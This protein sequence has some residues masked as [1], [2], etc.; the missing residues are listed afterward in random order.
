MRTLI[1]RFDETAN[2]YH[3]DDLISDIYRLPGVTSVNLEPPPYPFGDEVNAI[4]VTALWPLLSEGRKL[5]MV[6]YVKQVMPNLSIGSASKLVDQ[7]REWAEHW[8]PT[9]SNHRPDMVALEDD[10][11]W[12]NDDA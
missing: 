9:S 7:Y 10:W 4:V 2:V 3:I 8:K 11:S 1:V 6:A 5:P 12:R